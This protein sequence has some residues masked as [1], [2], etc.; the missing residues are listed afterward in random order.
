LNEC[1]TIEGECAIFARTL[2][3]VETSCF[4]KDCSENRQR[5]KAIQH[6]EGVGQKKKL[7]PLSTP[8]LLNLFASCC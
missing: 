3:G 2:H 7:L 5:K 8:S 6:K 1:K 4:A